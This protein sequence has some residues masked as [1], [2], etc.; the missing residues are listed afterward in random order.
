M[1]VVA[2]DYASTL[3]ALRRSLGKGHLT[4]EEIAVA[5]DVIQHAT[6]TLDTLTAAD[7]IADLAAN[8]ALD[9]RTA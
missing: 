5:I 8:N 3:A 2:A 4:G 1:A 9:G 7:D 6:N